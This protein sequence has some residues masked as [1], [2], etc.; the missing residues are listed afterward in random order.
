MD[1]L[2]FYNYDMFDILSIQ[3]GNSDQLS[4]MTFGGIAP[5]QIEG[6]VITHNTCNI[7]ANYWTLNL[8]SANYNNDIPLTGT[9]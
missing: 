3:L 1:S 6:A 5:N 9:A 2:N 4:F 7:Y 8:T